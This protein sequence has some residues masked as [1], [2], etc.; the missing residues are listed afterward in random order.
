MQI[1]YQ[2]FMSKIMETYNMKNGE[3]DLI[4]QYI[5]YYRIFISS[6]N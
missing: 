5:S 4:G 2:C 6:R 3:V 1:P